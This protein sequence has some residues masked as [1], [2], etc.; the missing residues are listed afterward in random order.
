M[1]RWPWIAAAALVVPAGCGGNH[2]AAPD[3]GAKPC[4]IGDLTAPAELEIVHLDGGNTVIQTQAMAQVPLLP[5]PQGGWIVLVGARARNLDGCNATLTTVLIDGCDQQIIKVDK[6]PTRLE[7]GGDGWGTST[8][9]TFGNLPVCPQLTAKRDLHDVPYNVQVVVE[10]PGGHKA[11][12][13]LA[14]VPVCPPGDALCTCQCDR[15]YVI[16]SSCN[17]PPPGGHE[18]CPTTRP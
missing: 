9:T 13:T 4:P 15:D 7:P 8:V 16:G 18:T 3:A 14:V 2:G 5:P 10:D 12:A 17:P 11:S 6:R 1:R